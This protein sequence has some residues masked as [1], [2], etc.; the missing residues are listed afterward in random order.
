MVYQ[1]NQLEPDIYNCICEIGPCEENNPLHHVEA[2]QNAI[3]EAI[4]EVGEVRAARMSQ[5]TGEGRP[6]SAEAG[7][8]RV[9]GSPPET[10]ASQEETEP[11]D[12]TSHDVVRREAIED[13]FQGT[14]SGKKKCL[15]LCRGKEIFSP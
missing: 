5:Q 2:V 11:E 8:G 4:E 3:Q 1:L 7:A 9:E 14:P 10:A 6:A 13:V 12:V 15:F